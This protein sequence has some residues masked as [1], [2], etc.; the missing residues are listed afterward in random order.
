MP[1]NSIVVIAD[2]SKYGSV[3]DLMSQVEAYI[4]HRK[5]IKII[6]SYTAGDYCFHSLLTLPTVIT[7]NLLTSAKGLI[8]RK[9]INFTYLAIQK[10]P[11]AVEPSYADIP[12]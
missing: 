11:I 5:K 2:L 9:K 4:S 6:R 8:P 10:T 1:A 3:I 7:K 12:F